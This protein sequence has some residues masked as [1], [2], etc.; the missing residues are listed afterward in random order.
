VDYFPQ[1]G[2]LPIGELRNLYNRCNGSE[3]ALNKMRMRSAP[4]PDDES[5]RRPIL[6]GA[7]AGSRVG[8]AP[9]PQADAAGVA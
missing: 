3:F 2:P 5:C 1:A 4:W 7:G 9:A 8:V 6:R